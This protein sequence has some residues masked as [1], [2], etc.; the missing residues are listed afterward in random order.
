MD[1]KT[2]LI[3]YLIVI[4]LTAIITYLIVGNCDKPDPPIVDQPKEIISLDDAIELYDTY[5]ENRSCVIEV[6]EKKTDS[7][8]TTLCRSDRKPDPE[9]IPSRSFFLTKEFLNQYLA[10]INQVTPDTVNVTGY[11]LYIGNY[12]DKQKFVS[13]K[14]IPDP[15]RNTFFMA[16]TTLSDGSD[17]H[18]GFTFMDKNGDGIPEILFLEDE[19]EDSQSPNQK[20]SKAKINTASFFSFTQGNGG[21]STIANEIGG[22]PPQ[23]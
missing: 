6:F 20:P 2:N 14:P 11:R 18:R 15:R 1:K 17:L 12:P 22:H 3:S 4:I 21:N 19:L 16:P 7:I 10:Y 13:G 9:F 23:N 8:L 5:T